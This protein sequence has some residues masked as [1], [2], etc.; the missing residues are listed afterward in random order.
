MV[1][2]FRETWV[3]VLISVDEAVRTLSNISLSPG[4]REFLNNLERGE[5]GLCLELLDHV[6]SYLALSL[7]PGYR[8][9]ITGTNEILA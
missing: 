4:G 5:T 7:P 3:N 8:N 1:Y 9:Y 2:D 6:R